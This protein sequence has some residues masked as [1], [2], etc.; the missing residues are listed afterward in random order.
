M[1]GAHDRLRV[2][3]VVA[4]A[5]FAVGEEGGRRIGTKNSLC[6]S[7]SVRVMGKDLV[8]KVRYTDPLVTG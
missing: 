4:V 6:G 7:R 3:R 2:G 5:G 8:H 1:I